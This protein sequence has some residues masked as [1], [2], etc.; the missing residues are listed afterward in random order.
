LERWRAVSWALGEGEFKKTLT[1][2]LD[3][4]APVCYNKRVPDEMVRTK[5]ENTKM[6]K[7]EAKITVIRQFVD[8]AQISRADGFKRRMNQQPVQDVQEIIV[9]GFFA[10]KN[11]AE[12]MEQAEAYCRSPY[13]VGKREEAEQDNRNMVDAEIVKR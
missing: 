9:S 12:A 11:R 6:Y 1:R 2:I 5:R 10:G 8:G 13:F 7:V 3:R 4:S